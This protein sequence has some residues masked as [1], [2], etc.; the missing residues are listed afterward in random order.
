MSLRNP[1]TP[2]QW[3]SDIVPVLEVL[4]FCTWTIVFNTCLPFKSHHKCHLHEALLDAHPHQ[5]IL[6]NIFLCLECHRVVFLPFFSDTWLHPA[7]PAF[8]LCGGQGHL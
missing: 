2:C 3:A 6:E 4:L 5:Q 7:V 1:R 8:S